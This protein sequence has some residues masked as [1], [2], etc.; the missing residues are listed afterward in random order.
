MKQKMKKIINL[1][2]LI[3]IAILTFIVAKN[4]PSI[5]VGK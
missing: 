4:I 5:L 1:T 2:V 3:I